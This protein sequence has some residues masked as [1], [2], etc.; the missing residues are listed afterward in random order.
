MHEP[1]EEADDY[2]QGTVHSIDVH[3]VSSCIHTTTIGNINNKT[4]YR[5]V[6]MQSVVF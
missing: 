2:P 5:T 4:S 6:R 1:L 3:L